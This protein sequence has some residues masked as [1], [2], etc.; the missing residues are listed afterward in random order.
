M[1]ILH[2]FFYCRFGKTD[3]HLVRKCAHPTCYMRACAKHN[4][5]HK[6]L[7]IAQLYFSAERSEDVVNDCVFLLSFRYFLSSCLANKKKENDKQSNANLHFRKK[8]KEKYKQ[9]HN[10]KI[11]VKEMWQYS[12]CFFICK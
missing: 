2:T 12:F 7:C 4:S 6:R 9:L 11:A 8:K 10:N 5:E 3:L 1:Q